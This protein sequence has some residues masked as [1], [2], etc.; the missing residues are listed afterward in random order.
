VLGKRPD[1]AQ[2]SM[3]TRE[4]AVDSDD[5]EVGQRLWPMPE[6][7]LGDVGEI[8]FQ[9]AVAMVPLIGAPIQ[10]FMAAAG[11]AY[12]ARKDDWLN[13]MAEVVDDLSERFEDFDPATL[14]NDQRFLSATAEAS[15]I[16]VASHRREKLQMLKNALINLA[17][18]REPEEVMTARFLRFV[19]EL[20]VDHF[21]F[22][23]YA[24]DPKVWFQAQGLHFPDNL[25]SAGRETFMAQAGLPL[26]GDESDM[27]L[28]DLARYGLAAEANRVAM[29]GHSAGGPFITSLGQRLLDFVTDEHG[30]FE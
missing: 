1:A 10:T 17:S 27:V 8:G 26:S 23:K 3:T 15:R 14:A 13:K 22:L 11:T 4:Q 25:I 16:A 28:R 24:S 18:G 19:E 5:G 20:E 12:E 6:R 7:N 29:S 21:V 9:A 2:I 30:R